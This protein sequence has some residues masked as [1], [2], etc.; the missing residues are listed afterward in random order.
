MNEL[1]MYHLVRDLVDERQ[2][3]AARERRAR[4]ARSGGAVG[5]RWWGPRSVSLRRR[6]AANPAPAIAT[7]T[8]AG[9]SR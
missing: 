6:H 8:A 3:E 4:L 7:A 1:L 2:A 9:A 5:W